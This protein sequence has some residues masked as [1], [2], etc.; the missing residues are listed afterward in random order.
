[1]PLNARSDLNLV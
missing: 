1:V